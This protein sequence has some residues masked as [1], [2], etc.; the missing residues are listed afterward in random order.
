MKLTQKILAGLGVVALT[1]GSLIGTPAKVQACDI[2]CE[3]ELT[4]RHQGSREQIEARLD[5]A[6]A[7]EAKALA[8]VRKPWNIRDIGASAR[9]EYDAMEAEAMAS[10][11]MPVGG[12]PVVGG[13]RSW[14]VDYYAERAKCVAQGRCTNR[15]IQYS[16]YQ[17]AWINCKETFKYQ[18][19]HK[20]CGGF[21]IR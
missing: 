2:A 20:I 9:A 12:A 19:A 4:Q 16:A 13:E 18:D 8:T 17:Q 1:A 7:A 21:P 5:A 6:N 11:T 15:K 3:I 10:G 14:L